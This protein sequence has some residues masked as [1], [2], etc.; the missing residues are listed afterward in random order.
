MDP[1]T[2]GGVARR[3][4]VLDRLLEAQAAYYVLTGAWPLVHRRSFERVTGPKS[5]YWLVQTVGLLV[6]SL[7]AAL[8][9][10]VRRGGPA[11]ETR[12]AAVTAAVALAG[13]DV[14]H[15]ARRRIS[16]VYLADAVVELFLV[17]GSLRGI[18]AGARA[19]RRPG[20]ID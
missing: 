12:F 17:A 10:G 16:P 18:R 8:A 19:S 2:P 4:R 1:R 6:L 14:V 7:G 5:D 13:I 3:D 20:F 11:P 9:Y 15:V